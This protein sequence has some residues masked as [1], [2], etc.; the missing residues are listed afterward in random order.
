MGRRASVYLVYNLDPV[1]VAWKKREARE[2]GR[3]PF[4]ELARRVGIRPNSLYRL[5]RERDRQP[6]PQTAALLAA[7]VGMSVDDLIV[8]APNRSHDGEETAQDA[9]GAHAH[10]RV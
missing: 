9:S 7:E 3:L 2:G 5:M 1:W 10:G 6:S 4:A 8:D